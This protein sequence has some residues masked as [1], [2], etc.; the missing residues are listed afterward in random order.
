M[1]PVL[2]RAGLA[3]AGA[4]VLAPTP[5]A[6]RLLLEDRGAEVRLEQAMDC[7]QPVRVQVITERADL[8]APGGERLQGLVDAARAMLGYECRALPEIRVTGALRGESSPRWAGT[9]GAATDWRLEPDAHHA[10]SAWVPPWRTGEPTPPPATPPPAAPPPA[11]RAPAPARSGFAVR[12]L[13]TGMT[14][15]TALAR[16]RE[17]FDVAPRYD[18]SRRELLA[19]LG[20]CDIDA[21]RPRAGQL[22]MR[23]LFTEGREPRSYRV[24][25]AQVVDRDQ[26]EAIAAQLRERFGAPAVDEEHRGTAWLRG[27]EPDRR[28]AWGVPTRGA[29]GEARHELEADIRVEEGVTVL[30]LDLIDAGLAADKPRYQVRF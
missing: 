20:G 2:R 28:L 6:A 4:V 25:Y 23:T 13:G 15:D 12:G 7:G 30:T 11:A 27:G 18:A 26:G 22:C 3:L 14:P 19:D 5:A 29:E 1:A 10:S 21:T 17:Q 8:F 16:A 9:A 24:H